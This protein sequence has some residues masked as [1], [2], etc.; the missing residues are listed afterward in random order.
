MSVPSPSPEPEI[1]LG[2]LVKA[3][4]IKGEL[5]FVGS[6]DFWTDVLRSHQLVMQQLVDGRVERRPVRVER[7]RP[8]GAH[9]V[10]RIDGVDDRD[11]AEAAVGGELFISESRLD[12]D[13]PPEELPFQVVGR[14]VRL[15]D[16][17]EIG[18]VTSVIFSAAHP[19][20]EVRGDEGVVL[21]PAVPEFVVARDGR[22]GVITIRPIPGLIDE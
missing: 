22:H 8:H 11:A 9:L 7:F 14:T 16:G 20:Y 18:T 19:V 17:R 21:I 15:E 13:L 10:V 1:Y 4:G 5:K 6:E 2:R 12:V 3:F